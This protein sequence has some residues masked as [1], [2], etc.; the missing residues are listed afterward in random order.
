M[1][2]CYFVDIISV[3]KLGKQITKFKYK[4]YY[5]GP[6]DSKI[7]T[8][9]NTL[10]DDEI[11]IPKSEY[12]SNEEYICYDYNTKQEKLE[13]KLLKSKELKIVDEVIEQLK[14]YGAKALSEIA[15]KTKPMLKIKA[16][17]GGNKH[18]NKKLDLKAK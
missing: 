13:F 2:L 12:A 18:I 10:V 6:F 14:G 8:E 7:Y 1:K 5:F 16:V 4:G 15:Y 17:Q 9:V 11:L 3:K